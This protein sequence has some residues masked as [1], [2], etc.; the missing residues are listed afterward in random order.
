MNSNIEFDFEKWKTGRYNVFIKGG[1]EVKQ[2][3]RFECDYLFPL[4]GV[5]GES[6]ETWSMK[7]KYLDASVSNLDLCLQLIS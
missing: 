6:V 1:A 5:V 2:L 4:Y 3:T 7:G